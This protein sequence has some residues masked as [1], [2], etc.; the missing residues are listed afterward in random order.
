MFSVGRVG[1]VAACCGALVLTGGASGV[2]GPGT[3]SLADDRE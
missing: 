1:F 2:T 3:E